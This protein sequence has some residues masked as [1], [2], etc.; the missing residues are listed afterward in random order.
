M[1]A[2]IWWAGG[3]AVFIFNSHRA[4]NDIF[5]LEMCAGMILFGLYVMVLE[6]RGPQGKKNV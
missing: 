6:R 3:V 5:L 2:G 1:V 4:A